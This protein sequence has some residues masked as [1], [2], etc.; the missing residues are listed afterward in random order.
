[1]ME[2]QFIT[3]PFGVSVFGSAIVRVSPDIAVITFLITRIRP[4]PNEAFQA[5]REAA[6][7]LQAYFSSAHIK[8][9]GS[10]RISL[11]DVFEHKSGESKFAGYETKVE[12]RVII[13]ELSRLEE[14]LAGI[15][16]AG[17]NHIRSVDFQTTRL[18]EI[19]VEARRQAVIAAREKAEVYCEA[20]G[21]EL[22]EV[23]HIED[24][25]PDQRQRTRYH[26]QGES[27]IDDND[28]AQAFDPGNIAVSGAVMVAFK[29][30]GQST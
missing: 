16:D 9:A 29:I 2:Q 21:I 5:I 8:D 24:L 25:T 11:M 7:Q 28:D 19:R 4:H 1:M 27:S 20:A 17:V 10:S 12:Y 22:G 6:Q 18:K 14:I 13:S 15:V 3:T 23:I 30:K 26:V